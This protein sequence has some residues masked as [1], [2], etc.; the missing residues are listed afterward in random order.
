MF[1]LTDGS[2]QARNMIQQAFNNLL[3]QSFARFLSVSRDSGQQER[4]PGG[5]RRLRPRRP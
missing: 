1:M 5:W 2:L 3:A 4:Q